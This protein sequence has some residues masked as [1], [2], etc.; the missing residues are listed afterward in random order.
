VAVRLVRTD[1]RV[2]QIAAGRAFD[3]AYAELIVPKL[4]GAP[5]QAEVLVSVFERRVSGIRAVVDLNRQAVVEVAPVQRGVSVPFSPREV[6][7][8]RTVALRSASV[9]ALAGPVQSAQSGYAID[10]LPV[11]APDPAL[12]PSGRCLELLFRRGNSYSTS[13]A[14][15][16]IPTQAVR[17]RRGQQ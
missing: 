4:S 2:M 16:E 8:A 1:A 15:V 5:R 11:S 6:E 7:L 10:Y 13:T 12:C 14:V 17:I 9:R 3:V